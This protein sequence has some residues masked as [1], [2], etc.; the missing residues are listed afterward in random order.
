M[1]RVRVSLALFS[2]QSI[3]LRK[4]FHCNYRRPIFA[5]FSRCSQLAQHSTSRFEVDCV[6]GCLSQCVRKFTRP[7]PLPIVRAKR[8]NLCRLVNGCNDMYRMKIMNFN[9]FVSGNAA[10]R[11]RTNNAKRLNGLDFD[12]K[13]VK[14]ARNSPKCCRRAMALC[15]RVRNAYDSNEMR[16]SAYDLK[17]FVVRS[18]YCLRHPVAW[19]QITCPIIRP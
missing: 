1:Y 12:A 7:A 15:V 16:R 13:E 19:S 10:R 3:Y 17:R 14:S 9:Y 18:H 6:R 4:T 5:R 8:A 11:G 2:A